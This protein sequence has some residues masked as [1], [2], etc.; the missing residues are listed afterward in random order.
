VLFVG[1][2]ET[3]GDLSEFDPQAFVHALFKAA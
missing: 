3:V 2:G 1:T